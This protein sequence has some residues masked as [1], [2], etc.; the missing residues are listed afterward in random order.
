MMCSTIFQH[1]SHEFVPWQFQCIRRLRAAYGT[2]AF[3]CDG[4]AGWKTSCPR[5]FTQMICLV[6]TWKPLLGA[7][8]HG[9]SSSQSI[10][11]C[12]LQCLS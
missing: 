11:V 6:G 4:Y 1:H 12:S 10:F 2:R 5:H 8:L 7:K 9:G 3:V